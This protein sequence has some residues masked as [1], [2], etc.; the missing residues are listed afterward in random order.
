M[1]TDKSKLMDELTDAFIDYQH[2]LDNPFPSHNETEAMKILK[3]S[4]DPLFRAK[5]QMLVGGVM[6]IVDGYLP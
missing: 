3:Y 6:H 1:K 5:V 2:R 4:S